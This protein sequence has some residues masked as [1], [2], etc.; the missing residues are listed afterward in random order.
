MIVII[1]ADFSCCRDARVVF[2]AGKNRDG[3]FDA[4]DLLAQVDIA[5][6]I[7]EER[8]CGFATALFLFDKAPSH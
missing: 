1:S 6:D 4:N 8:T 2:K 5:I 7:F 3:Y